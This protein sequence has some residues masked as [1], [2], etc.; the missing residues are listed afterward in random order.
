MMMVKISAHIA[1]KNKDL[2]ELKNETA[3]LLYHL[4]MMLQAMDLSLEDVIAVLKER[5]QSKG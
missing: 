1:A 5:H 3:D 4:L 2:N